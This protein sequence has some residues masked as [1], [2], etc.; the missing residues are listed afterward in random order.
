MPI[1]CGKWSARSMQMSQIDREAGAASI[2]AQAPRRR[3]FA[4]HPAA[5]SRLI[6]AS[7]RTTRF[8]ARQL[9]YHYCSR[10]SGLVPR[11]ALA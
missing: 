4:I 11:R 2:P 8:E 3:P 10:P 6:V 9:A 7:T 5:S 1:D